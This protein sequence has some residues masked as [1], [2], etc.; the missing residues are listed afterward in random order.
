MFELG[1]EKSGLIP[2]FLKGLELIVIVA[3]EKSTGHFQ[4]KNISKMPLS[5]FANLTIIY[6]INQ[7][8]K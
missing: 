7:K 2:G 8:G 3:T 4:K 6:Y 5:F 1:L